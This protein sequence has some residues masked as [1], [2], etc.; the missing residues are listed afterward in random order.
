[1]FGTIH[2]TDITGQKMWNYTLN[3]YGEDGIFERF[4]RRRDTL[5]RNALL[6]VECDLLLDEFQKMNLS[7]LYQVSL[8]NQN[9]LIEELKYVSGETTIE[10]C[11]ILSLKQKDPISL[12]K[13]TAEYFPPRIYKW[14]IRFEKS[15]NYEFKFKTDNV[16]FYPPDPTAAQYAAGGR[17]YEKTYDVEYGNEDI[18]GNW[19]K[20][21]D[22][23][24]TVWLEPA[25][26]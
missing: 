17:Y 15:F 20:V 19:Y 5:L 23:T 26:A 18:N 3:Y 11:S 22:G 14:N 6:R 12:A 24:I 10:T 2:N 21:A 7:P 16:T 4:W 9:Y 13:T 8:Q 1:V 25:L